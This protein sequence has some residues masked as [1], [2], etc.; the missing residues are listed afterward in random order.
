MLLMLEKSLKN[1]ML[2]LIDMSLRF[3]LPKRSDTTFYASVFDGFAI[4]LNA[5]KFG[6]GTSKG[7]VL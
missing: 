5:K 6:N 1:I 2:V 7:K 3:S 4:Q